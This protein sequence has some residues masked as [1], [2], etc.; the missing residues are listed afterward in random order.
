MI[1]IDLS[2]R[3]DLLRKIAALEAENAA[4]REQASK[5]GF[6]GV[7]TDR[8]WSLRRSGSGFWYITGIIGGRFF[9]MSPSSLGLHGS[10]KEAIAAAVKW[11][12]EQK[13]SGRPPTIH[14]QPKN[15]Q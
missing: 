15:A 13:A 14:P 8:G 6:L 1:K 7:L 9:D 10:P 12:A 2:S 3:D 4:L 5:G 11:A